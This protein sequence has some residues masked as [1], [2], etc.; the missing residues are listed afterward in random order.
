MCLT[1]Y[2]PQAYFNIIC[3]SSRVLFYLVPS[4]D[5]LSFLSKC[6]Q[7]LSSLYGKLSAVLCK[8]SKQDKFSSDIHDSEDRILSCLEQHLGKFK[9]HP[10]AAPEQKFQ[11]AFP[12]HSQAQRHKC[13]TGL[14]LLLPYILMDN[15]FWGYQIC[16]NLKLLGMV[17]EH[18]GMH[19]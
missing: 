17:H 6:P 2:K 16:N 18:S 7:I 11:T 4:P 19:I 3:P 10:F 13:S 9:G 5:Q 14:S 1:L 8:S 12:W 15:L